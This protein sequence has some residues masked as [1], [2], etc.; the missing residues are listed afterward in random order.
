MGNLVETT[1][2]SK[3]TGVV[4]TID[5]INSKLPEI[6][7]NSQSAGSGIDLLELKLRR[8][9]AIAANHNIEIS[10]T[11]Y[12]ALRTK[13]IAAIEEA[14]EKIQKASEAQRTLTKETER[15]AEANG[16]V[17]AAVARI[18]AQEK[19]TAQ[20][21]TESSLTNRAP[22][23]AAPEVAA[24]TAL[25]RTSQGFNKAAD[26]ANRLKK[27]AS[28]LSQSLISLSG[29]PYPEA[30]NQLSK[31]LSGSLA[32]TVAIAAVAAIGAAVIS[33]INDIEEATKKAV[34]NIRAAANFGIGGGFSQR[35]KDIE[36]LRDV[37]REL[38]E[39][40]ALGDTNPEAAI[41]ERLQKIVKVA[42][43]FRENDLINALFGETIKSGAVTN[44]TELRIA[45]EKSEKI[46]DEFREKQRAKL[47]GQQ[48]SLDLRKERV[49]SAD[50]KG[51]AEIEK[52]QKQIKDL[53]SR[54]DIE[55][56]NLSKT[57]STERNKDFQDF[58]DKQRQG[59]EKVAQ[60]D[61]KANEAAL[62]SIRA[63]RNEFQNDPFASFY[64]KA[65]DRLLDFQI[66][67]KGLGDKIVSQ[68]AEVN[69]RILALD[70]FKT[71]LS[72]S[73]QL[74][75]TLVDQDTLAVLGGRGRQQQIGQEKTGFINNQ[76]D[77]QLEIGRLQGRN[78]DDA[79]ALWRR[80]QVIQENLSGRTASE[81]IEAA[82]RGLT[83]DQLDQAGVRN[84]R[85]GA[86]SDIGQFQQEDFRRQQRIR[87]I[88]DESRERQIAIAEK[89][90]RTA[91]SPEQR[92]L[93]IDFGLNATKDVGNLTTA[94]VESRARLLDQS[95]AIQQDVFKQQAERENARLATD[96]RQAAATETLVGILKELLNKQSLVQI[97][98]DPQ[99]NSRIDSLPDNN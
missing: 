42:P 9:S 86:L 16:K 29:V 83:V 87:Q 36:E 44:E 67:S 17:D 18:R 84:A 98:V 40:R 80:I 10:K 26:G 32:G 49:S 53:Q 37:L 77:N 82:T 25:E 61:G 38:E 30:A 57:I 23:F 62:R 88:E 52:E 66:Q 47:K 76:F 94:Q 81:A 22:Q 90:L 55:N 21:A 93:A 99:L 46:T 45:L 74:S 3:D 58:V 11:D 6:V 56:L 91:E 28:E 78:I 65:E 71:K 51:L 75:D 54:Y 72:L 64:D 63:L 85:I 89:A 4:D 60:A 50:V 69:N 96:N 12:S 13:G 70:I 2:S 8:L 41:N 97:T 35:K 59:S 73:S 24:S 5:K 95:L 15:T 68:F 1:F 43:G 31:L 92:R 14:T 48:E 79:E 39:R 34:E 19:R 33:K 7:R 20:I 27:G